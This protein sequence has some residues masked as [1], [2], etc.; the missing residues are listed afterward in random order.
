MHQSPASTQETLVHR[1]DASHSDSGQSFGCARMQFKYDINGE[2]TAR[3]GAV[4]VKMKRN[5]LRSG[6]RTSPRLLGLLLASALQPWHSLLCNCSPGPRR[7]VCARV[8]LHEA[9]TKCRSSQDCSTSFH[10]PTTGAS[11]PADGT[12]QLPGKQ[13]HQ[14]HPARVL[15][16]AALHPGPPAG[17]ACWSPAQAPLL[18]TKAEV[19]MVLSR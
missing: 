6:V 19:G 16:A 8:C 11:K 2:I 1:R 15:A 14:T 12:Q 17:S 13:Q 4:S 3:H 7:A 18:W 9:K 5:A 10:E